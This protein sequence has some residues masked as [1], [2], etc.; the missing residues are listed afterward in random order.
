MKV[1]VVGDSCR[2]VHVYG[3][4]DRMCPDAP[5]PVFRPR[6]KREN[7]GMAGNV[8]ENFRSLGVVCDLITNT[9]EITKTRYIDQARD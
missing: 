1:L 2:D 3:E 7:K 8:Y 9:S 4:C 5:L 6:F